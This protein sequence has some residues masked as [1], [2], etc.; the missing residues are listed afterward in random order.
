MDH[1]R[2]RTMT[3]GPSGRSTVERL[4]LA[5]RDAVDAAIADGSTIDGIATVIRARGGNCSGSAV[6][7]AGRATHMNPARFA[8]AGSPLCRLLSPV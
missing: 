5:V 2:E 3:H 8:A 4:P 1:E 7:R 6:D